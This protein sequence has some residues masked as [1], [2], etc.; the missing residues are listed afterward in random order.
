MDKIDNGKKRECID[1][2]YRVSRYLWDSGTDKSET[3][4]RKIDRL[5]KTIE[6]AAD[7]VSE[8]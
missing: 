5:I 6:K 4:Q 1:H 2:L 3:E 7:I 8:L